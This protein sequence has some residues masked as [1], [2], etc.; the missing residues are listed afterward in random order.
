[1][2]FLKANNTVYGLDLDKVILTGFSA[3]ANI[4][5]NVGFAQNNP[6]FPNKLNNGIQIAGVINFSGP[7][8]G[9]DVWSGYLLSTKMNSFKQ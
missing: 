5:T 6:E 8:D 3:G 2:N 9:V 4:A 7:V 1:L